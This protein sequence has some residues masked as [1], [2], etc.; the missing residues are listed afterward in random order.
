MAYRPPHQRGK[1]RPS[2]RRTPARRRPVERCVEAVG[3]TAWRALFPLCDALVGA[4][5]SEPA[6]ERKRFRFS[7]K[8]AAGGTAGDAKA[9]PAESSVES[10]LK[11]ILRTMEAAENPI[12]GAARPADQRPYK[13]EG[14]APNTVFVSHTLP[15]EAFTVMKR[16]CAKFKPGSEVWE[17]LYSIAKRAGASGSTREGNEV[18]LAVLMPSAASSSGVK[19][20][21][22]IKK[23]SSFISSQGRQ[24]A[25]PKPVTSAFLHF[26]ETVLATEDL[27]S[28]AW[29]AACRCVGS[30]AQAKAVTTSRCGSFCTSIT[31]SLSIVL[32]DHEAALEREG[33]DSQATA[34]GAA[35]LV[36][37]RTLHALDSSPSAASMTL[38]LAARTSSFGLRRLAV[39]SAA[40]V[41]AA[42]PAAKTPAS[43]ERRPARSIPR[44]APVNPLGAIGDPFPPVRAPR[45]FS[46]STALSAH[47]F[48]PFS[49]QQYLHSNADPD[50]LL[51]VLLEK[52]QNLAL[53]PPQ[54]LLPARRQDGKKRLSPPVDAKAR[55]PA[56]SLKA[57]EPVAGRKPGVPF[58]ES[59]ASV[60]VR[61]QSLLLLRRLFRRDETE[62]RSQ[63]TKIVKQRWA[64]VLPLHWGHV[65]DIGAAPGS[66]G[67]PERGII[68][69]LL[70]DPSD[71]IRALAAEC[72][73]DALRLCPLAS[74]TGP[75]SSRVHPLLLSPRFWHASVASSS[76]ASPRERVRQR[77]AS[78]IIPGAPRALAGLPSPRAAMSQKLSLVS[79]AVHFAVILALLCE[80]ADTAIQSTIRCAQALVASTPYHRIAGEH[81]RPGVLPLLSTA[82]VRLAAPAQASKGQDDAGA[83]SRAGGKGARRQRQSDKR[84]RA[85]ERLTVQ[86]AFA[87]IAAALD[88]N[89][90]CESMLWF[91]RYAGPR[92]T[93]SDAASRALAEEYGRLWGKDYPTGTMGALVDL[94]Q[95]REGAA[96][97]SCIWKVARSYR[98]CLAVHWSASGLGDLLQRSAKS[99]EPPVAIAA[100][101]VLE[102]WTKDSLPGLQESQDPQDFWN[103]PGAFSFVR[104][105]FEAAY[106]RCD[107]SRGRQYQN[108]R[109]SVQSRVLGCVANIPQRVWT[110]IAKAQQVAV[111]AIIRD[112]CGSRLPTVRASA[113]RCIGVIGTYSS[114]IHA[115]P[116]FFQFAVASA[117]RMM[118]EAEAVASVRARACWAV[119]NITDSDLQIGISDGDSA[120]AASQSTPKTPRAHPL[121]RLLAPGELLRLI[122]SLLKMSAQGGPQRLLPNALRSLGNVAAWI[123]GP[124][125]DDARTAAMWERICSTLHGQLAPAAT[126][127]EGSAKTLW[128][129]T[130]AV[131][132]LF[133]NPALPAALGAAEGVRSAHEQTLARL[134]ELA[135]DAKA[136]NFKV[137]IHA[138]GAIAKLPTL[139]HF[140]DAKMYERALRTLV[141]AARG[142]TPSR[143]GTFAEFQYQGVLRAKLYLS[144]CHLLVLS[145]AASPG[146]DEYRAVRQALGNQAQDLV[147]VLGEELKGL[148][149][150]SEPQFWNPNA[151]QVLS[152]FRLAAM[153]SLQLF[154][155]ARAALVRLIQGVDEKS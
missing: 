135:A 7:R 38:A 134:L 80:S 40:A 108:P 21:G 43:T 92:A 17:V 48:S 50:A 90:P 28:G 16:L 77:L 99:P 116:K 151:S 66:G 146:S 53:A 55:P 75:L 123:A 136:K 69:C 107:P 94:A 97:I 132:N 18:L 118:V 128:N 125:S 96:A 121:Q 15:D 25:F 137:R 154:K 57:K 88:T 129:A 95:G 72:L 115:Y 85:G 67:P 83:W 139:A 86:A 64:D 11:A 5:G 23:V 103:V 130:Y 149:S 73:A 68:A 10:K 36:G 143:T 101:K 52:T 122:E 153:P 19:R 106:R 24:V 109:H 26:L 82:L 110:R 2:R 1:K 14:G 58:E 144:L 56:T 60:S 147:R 47:T 79:G 114:V 102:E 104:G 138:A 112:G 13:A 89:E 49:S 42:Q 124:S 41:A 150:A 45:S 61:K 113:C 155:D 152:E 81:R 140:A 44:P 74:W 91:L 31:S 100:F 120:A 37:L 126:R 141:S 12:Q 71:E 8:K 127:R 33:I 84:A 78:A 46:P 20:V 98:G 148:E 119:A 70:L 29:K 30:L 93:A 142:F 22:R 4:E 65:V 35:L 76:G 39:R 6:G 51:K 145:A 63:K 87:G 117:H 59:W 133:S 111:L 54:S 105:E 34:R 62:K 3:S 32:E 9:S 131:G 27:I